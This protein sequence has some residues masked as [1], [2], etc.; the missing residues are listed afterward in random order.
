MA[1]ATNKLTAHSTGA[2]V[3]LTDEVF[4]YRVVGLVT[5]GQGDVVQ[6]EDCYFLDVV[7]VPVRNLTERRLRVVT[8]GYHETRSDQ[9]ARGLA[10]G[11][12]SADFAFIGTG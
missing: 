8:P 7:S 10:P 12:A 9:A 5:G 6:L 4:L 11:G 2:G 3:Y 1:P